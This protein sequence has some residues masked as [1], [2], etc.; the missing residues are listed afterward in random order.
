MQGTLHTSQLLLYTSELLLVCISVPASK[1]RNSKRPFMIDYPNPTDRSNLTDYSNPMISPMTDY[2]AVFTLCDQL[3]AIDHSGLSED[4][5]KSQQ[6]KAAVLC[7]ELLDGLKSI[8]ITVQEA[9]A[10]LGFSDETLYRWKKPGRGPK[11]IYV[12]QL[13]DI[14]R[15]EQA[16]H[17][18]KRGNTKRDKCVRIGVPP[19]WDAALIRAWETALHSHGMDPKFVSV[20][21]MVHEL[22]DAFRNGDIDVAIHNEFL[23]HHDQ[24]LKVKDRLGL[25]IKHPL[26]EFSG[27][28]IYARRDFVQ[29][30]RKRLL[31]A[32]GN[33]EVVE[34]LEATAVNTPDVNM[35]GAMQSEDSPVQERRHISDKG[36]RTN[37]ESGYAAGSGYAAEG[38]LLEALRK[39]GDGDGAKMPPGEKEAVLRYLLRGAYLGVE[40]GT[41]MELA[42][43]T[44]YHLLSLDLDRDAFVNLRNDQVYDFPINDIG[45][46][47]NLADTSQAFDAFVDGSVDIFCG[48]LAHHYYLMQQNEDHSPEQLNAPGGTSKMGSAKA[49]AKK[50]FRRATDGETYVLLFCPDDLGVSATNGIVTRQD[51]YSASAA[52]IA[53]VW[54]AGIEQFQSWYAAA[55]GKDEA[56]KSLAYIQLSAMMRVVEAQTLLGTYTPHGAR[57]TPADITQTAKW[58]V[59]ID[60]WQS[61]HARDGSQEEQREEL[62]AFARRSIDLFRQDWRHRVWRW[63]TLLTDNC[64]FFATR[65]ERGADYVAGMVSAPL[66]AALE[67]KASDKNAPDKKVLV[68]RKESGEYKLVRMRQPNGLKTHVVEHLSPAEQKSSSRQASA[69]NSKTLT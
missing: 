67:K 56:A 54:H 61:E 51:Q 17:L 16:V 65:A 29:S 12:R 38:L 55:K 11:P 1:K 21:H 43:R 39:L 3:L 35:P 30:V 9:A 57:I 25:Q 64:H 2:Q 46:D 58:P 22:H 28:F 63:A 37:D 10:R 40:R 7:G 8:G 44:A 15:E 50:T 49:A 14:V 24:A 34:S 59:W 60:N 41:G 36:D 62:T 47:P 26:Y 31:A 69:P 66:P 52:I 33:L 6:E 19:F 27:Y 23:I 18:I 20:S 53:D 48:G 32:A 5:R 45:N 13:R 4:Q 68:T 42:C